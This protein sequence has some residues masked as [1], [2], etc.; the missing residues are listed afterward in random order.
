MSEFVDELRLAAS[1]KMIHKAMLAHLVTG[2]VQEK[3]LFSLVHLVTLLDVF[4]CCLQK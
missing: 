3:E 4:S 1:C 2:R